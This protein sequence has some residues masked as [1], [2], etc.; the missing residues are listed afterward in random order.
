M[1]RFRGELQVAERR[2]ATRERQHLEDRRLG[3]VEFAQHGDGPDLLVSH[4]LFGGFDI[5]LAIADTYAGNGYRIVAPSRFGYLGSSLPQGASPAVQAEAYAAVLDRLEIERAIVFGYSGGGPSAIQF[6]LRHPDRTEALILLASAL[7]GRAGS[8][9]KP[10]A[11]L[12]FG[13]EIFFWSL[14]TYLPSTMARV[15]GVPAGF[16]LTGAQR[17]TVKRYGASLLPVHPRKRGI[18][19]DLYVSN[20]AVQ[21]F[22]LEDIRV[23]AVVINAVD[24]PMSAFEN[25]ESAARR[26]TGAKLVAIENGG[27]LLLGNERRVQDEIDAVAGQVVEGRASD[28]G[29]PPTESPSTVR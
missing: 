8:L 27:H 6:A 15:L 28:I 7:P 17:A 3:T 20:P 24:D 29:A 26:I 2:L 14:N 25:A 21:N 4:P 5:G 16:H 12:L 19:F 13:S 11:R 1:T 23:R 22:P 18:L 10:L 9:P